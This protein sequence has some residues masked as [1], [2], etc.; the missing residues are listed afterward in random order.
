[1]GGDS[2]MIWRGIGYGNKLKTK[3]ITGKLNSK[4]Y[5]EIIDEQINTYATRIAGSKYV[6][7]NNKKHGHAHRESSKII[8]FEQKNSC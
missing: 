5:V 3:F 6:F 8:L 7:Q 2:K 4:K 1:M